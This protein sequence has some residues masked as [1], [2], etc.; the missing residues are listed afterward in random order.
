MY[1]R[2]RQ[3]WV[4]AWICL[5][6]P[7]A[8]QRNG[9]L[10]PNIRW[11]E[12]RHD[13]LRVIY[14]AGL[15]ST[16]YR[17]AGR[18]LQLARLDP[19]TRAGRFNRVPVLLQPYTNL[20][21]GYVA[22]GPFRSELYLQ[23]SERIFDLGSYDWTDIL[24]LH[25]FRHVQQVNAANHGISHVVKAVTGELGFNI[26][27]DLAIPAWFREGNAVYTETKWTAQGRGRLSRFLL[28]FYER[29]M[30]GEPWRFHLAL[31]GSY[32]EMTPDRYALGFL[33][34][35]YGNE[36][37]GEKAWDTIMREAA[38]LGNPVNAFGARIK[39]RSGHWQGGLY[40]HAIQWVGDRYRQ[41]SEA[42][43][44][45]AE[46]P[47]SSKYRRA[48]KRK[49]FVE[50]T[51]PAFDTDGTLYAAVRTFDHIATISRIDS[52][53]RLRRIR[54][55]GR[56]EDGQFDVRNG[57]FAW[58]ELR[59]D[60]RWQRKDRNVLVLY[61]SHTRKKRTFRPD[62]GYFMPS[63]DADG[64]RVAVLHTDARGRHSI[65]ILDS[66]TGDI[67]RV[68]E[69]PDNEYFG[70]PTFTPDGDHLVTAVRM[71]DGRMAL[72][73]FDL[74]SGWRDPLT[75]PSFGVIGRPVIRGDEVYFTAGFDRL[76]QVYALSLPGRTLARISGGQRAHY[77]P[78]VDPKTG[79]LLASE[80][81]L[82]GN[83]LVYLPG[84]EESRTE[85]FVQD[86]A[87]WFDF[88]ARPQNEEALP[89]LP[90]ASVSR[91][92]AWQ[93]AIRPHSFFVQ[94]LDPTWR[95]MVRSD[96]LLNTVST[97]A[98]MEL[99][100]KVNSFGPFVTARISYLFPEILLAARQTYRTIRYADGS[101]LRT[102]NTKGSLGF[103]VPVRL[104]EGGWDIAAATQLTYHIGDVRRRLDAELPEHAGFDYSELGF[105]FIRAMR[106]AYRQAEPRW[107]Q[108]LDFVAAQ[109]VAKTPVSQ[110]YVSAALAVPGF[111]ATH[112]C[113]LNGEFVRQR[114]I[115]SVVTIGSRF[116]GARG[117]T[118]VDGREQYAVGLTYGFPLAYPDFGL[119]SVL[120][121][122]RIRMQ[123]FVDLAHT[124]GFDQESFLQVSAGAE[125][126]AESS[127]LP[128]PLGLRIARLL[129][130]PEQ[131]HT[132]F[133][134]FI[135]A[136][137]F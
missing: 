114:D 50:Y 123:P 17:V 104:T 25:E 94:A 75:E 116:E 55:L 117:F 134:I 2:L 63:F 30:T 64:S 72:V 20:S 12:L 101:R 100:R 132:R 6:L 33:M 26:A 21:N 41:F 57:I 111:V 58:S 77:D 42:P 121:L 127:W 76:D 136:T 118:Q 91:Y 102:T 71:K 48:G 7:L 86:T 96:N 44:T 88:P 85:A 98:G 8:A 69:S 87:R 11:S 46:I 126:I 27:Y 4:V 120:Y 22:L 84:E 65:R 83:R 110:V 5:A 128:I 82:E 43:L 53:G 45:Y 73:R 133:E 78:A 66:S 67:L 125:W 103:R 56:K 31:R 92:R 115:G 113:I 108:R 29:I 13:S 131:G 47:V 19:V 105:S 81:R 124:L 18:M 34:Q 68:L 23:P 74:D 119:G 59:Y 122:R 51:Y 95:F 3:V 10:P 36:V 15:D 80:Y 1:D 137:R 109:Q 99:N 52:T 70:Y 54:A 112:F 93:G 28:P 40:R 129:R 130:G 14:P 61:D 90:E 62:K 9:Y 97:A 79:A 32:R 49:P 106:R 107:A 16:A 89:S 35:M 24:S 135:P 60:P 39:A 37:F 38:R